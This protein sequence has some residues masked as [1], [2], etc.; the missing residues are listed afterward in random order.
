METTQSNRNNAAESLC[1]YNFW[2]LLM[3]D[4]PIRR[5]FQDPDT[6][7]QKYVR[8]GMTAL[9]IG[10][11]P[12]D[13]TRS[14]AALAG[15]NGHVIAIDLQEEMLRNAQKKYEKNGSGAPVTWHQCRADTLGITV[16]AD[17]ALSFYMVH[18]VPDMDRLFHEV[19]MLLKPGGRYLVVEPVFHVT[20]DMFK[21]TLAAAARAGFVEKDRPEISLSR[22]VLLERPAGGQDSSPV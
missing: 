9:D 21:D 10:C 13:F 12:G 22:A 4:N 1:L 19:S 17:F 8:P 6:I 15:R 20:D 16:M 3:L 14:M 5:F 7:L 2:H 11:G 18:E